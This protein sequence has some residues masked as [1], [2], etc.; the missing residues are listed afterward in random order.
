M[1]STPMELIGWVFRRFSMGRGK[2]SRRQVL[3]RLTVEPLEQRA[4]LSAVPT[5]TGVGPASGPSGGNTLVTIRG[6]G[7]TGATAVDFGGVAATSFTVD[8]DGVIR[9]ASPAAAAGKV[10]VRVTGDGGESAASAIDTFTYTA[11][12]QDALSVF[13]PPA[14][15]AVDAPVLV[16]LN[17]TASGTPAFRVSTSSPGD[18]LGNDLTTTFMP[19]TNQVL[20]IVTSRG[21][22][23]FQLLANYTPE[24]VQHIVGLIKSGAYA[25]APRSTASSRISLPR[26]APALPARAARSR[27]N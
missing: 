18:P 14:S 20:K 22:L 27:T 2:S 19:K 25:N 7:F 3:R 10:D 9:A 4:L 21:E 15:V 17:T 1:R 13:A 23:D 6:T 16:G 26:A 12:P 24:T 8:S 5:V 11:G